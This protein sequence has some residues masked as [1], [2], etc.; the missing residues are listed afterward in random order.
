MHMKSVNANGRLSVS[1]SY[2]VFLSDIPYP[3]LNVMEDVT[4]ALELGLPFN[5]TP[6][7]K[8][9]SRVTNSDAWAD[10]LYPH[11][12]RE[13]FFG[14]PDTD[15]FFPVISRYH[16]GWFQ[17][18]PW[19]HASEPMTHS[20]Y[21]ETRPITGGDIP[22]EVVH[23]IAETLSVDGASHRRPV[24][25]KR[26]LAAC[27]L[28]CR[29]WTP[30]CQAKIWNRITLR[31]ARD[32]Q[33]LLNFLMDP[34]CRV[35]GYILDL[36][37]PPQKLAGPP[38]I[39]HLASLYPYLPHLPRRTQGYRNI[40]SPIVHTLTGPLR[41]GLGPLRSIHQALP[42]A[43]PV[44]SSYIQEVHLADVHFRRFDDLADFVAELRDLMYFKC[45]SLT[46]AGPQPQPPKVLGYMPEV[47][48]RN[49]HFSWASMWLYSRRQRGASQWQE[50]IDVEDHKRIGELA[51]IIGCGFEDFH[52][53]PTVK[54]LRIGHHSDRQG[55]PQHGV[56]RAF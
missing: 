41:R 45:D 5:R 3:Y 4:T 46:I 36:Q 52:S 22:I 8:E 43:P 24:M 54:S 48:M 7:F 16:R 20:S 34:T 49:C 53:V 25:R 29:N 51:R 19:P 56:S 15:I 27:A 14:K 50:R 37:V 9:L 12:D 44:F 55:R 18:K 6:G 11:L 28:M 2:L 21:A 32:V 33:E 30:V 35:R 17:I 40:D 26:E 42:R 13:F 47:V 10:L 39:H 31:C 38:W 23:R 1:S